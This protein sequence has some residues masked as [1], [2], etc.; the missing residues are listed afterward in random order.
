MLCK[1]IC[2]VEHIPF[3]ISRGNIFSCIFE[4]GCTNADGRIKET[5][6]QQVH[7]NGAFRYNISGLSVGKGC[8]VFQKFGLAADVFKEV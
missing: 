7:I 8:N 4:K 5:E 1:G 3:K 2:S 6:G